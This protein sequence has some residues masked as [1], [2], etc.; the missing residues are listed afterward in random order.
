MKKQRYFSQN[1]KGFGCI[2]AAVLLILSSKELIWQKRG[3]QIWLSMPR[4]CLKLS[5]LRNTGISGC[6]SQIWL[7]RF[8]H[9]NSLEDKISNTAATIQPNPFWFWEKSDIWKEDKNQ[10]SGL[11]SRPIPCSEWGSKTLKWQRPEGLNFTPHLLAQ[12]SLS[13][14]LNPGNHLIV[15]IVFKIPSLNLRKTIRNVFIRN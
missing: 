4:T 3:S 1:Q 8:C 7:P 11:V 15:I 12:R 5:R 6:D 9:I 13:H 2:V 14:I 10:K